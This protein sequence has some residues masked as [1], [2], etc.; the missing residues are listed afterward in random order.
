MQ[1]WKRKSKV[2]KSLDGTSYNLNLPY[3]RE[4]ERQKYRYINRLIDRLKW[5]ESEI[6]EKRQT[7]EKINHK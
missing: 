2:K 4:K 1:A 5:K 3:K 7:N 6:D